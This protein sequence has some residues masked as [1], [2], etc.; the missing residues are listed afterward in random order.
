MQAVCEFS[1][2]HVFGEMCKD[3]ERERERVRRT[4]DA[5]TIQSFYAVQQCTIKTNGVKDTELRE[6]WCSRKKILV[7]EKRKMKRKRKRKKDR[8]EPSSTASDK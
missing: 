3:R 6:E 4:T 8:L 7:P 2:V 1:P 5:M